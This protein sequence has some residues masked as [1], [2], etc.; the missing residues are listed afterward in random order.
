MKRLA[1][2]VMV[3]LMYACSSTQVSYDYDKTVDFTKFKT[4]AYTPEALALPIQEL[5]RNRL[6]AAIDE[7]MTKRGYSKV[8]TS[9]DVLIDVQVKADMKQTATTTGTGGMYGYRW[10]GGMTTTQINDYVEGTLFINMIANNNLV[11]QGRAVKTLD[12]SASPEK[13][14]QN[15]NNAVEDIYTKYPKPVAAKK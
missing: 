8:T 13:R 14:T 12:E 5:N 4:Y 15:I 3:L 10:G 1:P 9:P 2:F 7:Q 6:L 11:W